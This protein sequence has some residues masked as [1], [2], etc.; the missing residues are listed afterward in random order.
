[1]AGDGRKLAPICEVSLN[2]GQ[3]RL[4]PPLPLPV[5]EIDVR[6]FV[7]RA[8]DHHTDMGVVVR[9]RIAECV[10]AEVVDVVRD[11]VR[12]ACAEVIGRHDNE[13]IQDADWGGMFDEVADRVARRLS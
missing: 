6:G 3:Q 10:S 9:N 8:I 1:M 2:S 13:T 5:P 7:I 11:L 12:D 4:P